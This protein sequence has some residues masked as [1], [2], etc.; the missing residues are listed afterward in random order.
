MNTQSSPTLV[1]RRRIGPSETDERTLETAELNGGEDEDDVDD[2]D[3]DDHHRRRREK[4]LNSSGIGRNTTLSLRR[5]CQLLTGMKRDEL[6]SSMNV[7][8][9]SKP[10][11]FSVH[12]VFTKIDTFRRR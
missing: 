3:E 5:G 12:G 11:V 9:Q 4:L 8:L 6:F 1:K 7:S 2:D 10:D